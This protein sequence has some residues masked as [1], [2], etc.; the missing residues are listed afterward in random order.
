MM[1]IP[2]AM[3]QM[4]T[5][6]MLLSPAEIKRYNGVAYQG[7]MQETG[8]IF[9][10]WKSYGGTETTVNGVYSIEDTAQVTTR[11]RPDIKANCYLKLADGR[12]YEILGEPENPDMANRYLIFKVKRVKGGA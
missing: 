3:K 10:N 5:S 7:E 2:K 9:V 11:Y 12:T 4:R 8:T 6:V 1:Y